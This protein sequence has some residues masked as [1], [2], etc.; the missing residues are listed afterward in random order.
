[1]LYPVTLNQESILLYEEYNWNIGRAT[2]PSHLPMALIF[3][4]PLNVAAFEEALQAVINRHVGL[5]AAFVR[6]D[7]MDLSQREMKIS[8]LLSEKAIATG[9][10]AQ[11]PIDSVTVP[12]LQVSFIEH[13]DP[14]E[15]EIEIENILIRSSKI[16]FDYS[17]PPFVKAHLFKIAS[18]S[19][20]FILMIHH[21][22]CDMYSLM[23]FKRDMAAFYNSIAF[24]GRPA[25]PAIKRHFTDFA[26]EQYK[27]AAGNGFDKMIQ[28]WR[29]Q[30]VR[31]LPAQIHWS[32]LPASFRGTIDPAF[33]E[34]GKD[35]LLIEYDM[36]ISWEVFA[37]RE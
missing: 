2:A 1:M 17:K 26:L 16:P 31:Y 9:M 33:P 24:N 13:L 14:E 29:E 32:D 6:A 34:I 5:R 27:G 35:E 28:Y 21:L 11:H 4:G 12:S 22:V 8:E 25:V 23:I 19:H 20:L 10:Y 3:D 18:G 30:L 7:E 15:K 37:R 36:I